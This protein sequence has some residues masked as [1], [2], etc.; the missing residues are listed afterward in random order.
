MIETYNMYAD[1]THSA[2]T[3]LSDIKKMEPIDGLNR[4]NKVPFS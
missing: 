4:I 3:C 1:L 2:E